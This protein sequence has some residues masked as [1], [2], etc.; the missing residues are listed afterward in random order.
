MKKV[1]LIF[2]FISSVMILSCGRPNVKE[3]DEYVTLLWKNKDIAAFDTS[4]SSIG[5]LRKSEYKEVDTLIAGFKSGVIQGLRAVFGTPTTAKTADE[6]VRQEYA[7][8][9]Q[10]LE[11]ELSDISMKA[12]KA[13]I[14][15]SKDDFRAFVV[16]TIEGKDFLI[17]KEQLD[18]SLNDGLQYTTVDWA[19]TDT[20]TGFNATDYG[21]GVS[22]STLQIG[23]TD[24][25]VCLYSKNKDALIKIKNGELNH[26]KGTI[27]KCNFDA[28]SMTFF[29]T[30][31]IS[32]RVY[33]NVEI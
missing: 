2:A 13:K 32:S 7:S 28:S 3:V 18:S 1:Y 27:T 30:T 25:D 11:K 14:V 26:F 29:G 21:G 24:I 19:I 10:E 33:I 22:F 23:D 12:S 15:N 16:K 4:I 8:K 6:F 20:D 31:S 17:Q 9:I 5:D